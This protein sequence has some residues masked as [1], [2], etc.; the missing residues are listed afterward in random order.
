MKAIKRL[1]PSGKCFGKGQKQPKEKSVKIWVSLIKFHA[2]TIQTNASVLVL[3]LR[4]KLW[5]K[6]STTSCPSRSLQFRRIFA[7]LEAGQRL[8]HLHSERESESWLAWL[9]QVLAMLCQELLMKF[10]VSVTRCGG[11][12]V[13]IQPWGVILRHKGVTDT[14]E[15]TGPKQVLKLH[16]CASGKIGLGILNSFF[17]L[18]PKLKY[19]SYLFNWR[20][21]K[22]PISRGC[23][24]ISH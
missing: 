16:G 5:W 12:I 18:R 4:Q 23:W 13:A 7:T 8:L 24:S 15:P 6:K 17:V 22:W 19:L 20:L 3:L 10:V 21:V 1:S 9:L 11:L 14:T 2:S